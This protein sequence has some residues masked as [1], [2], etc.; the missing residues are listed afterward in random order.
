MSSHTS[1][2]PP[3]R[4]STDTTP[5]SESE[6]RESTDELANVR[7]QIADVRKSV[8]QNINYRLSPGRSKKNPQYLL[9]K[10]EVEGYISSLSAS[11]SGSRFF[12]MRPSSSHRTEIKKRFS[13]GTVSHESIPQETKDRGTPSPT[14]TRKLPFTSANTPLPSSLSSTSKRRFSLSKL[15]RKGERKEKLETKRY[16]DYESAPELKPAKNE[17]RVVNN[18]EG[19]T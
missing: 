12:N 17:L 2:Y 11:R 1:P 15:F 16:E 18:A 8:E 3:L 7:G 5:E 10:Q 19:S 13:S 6:E 4:F 9:S 14:P